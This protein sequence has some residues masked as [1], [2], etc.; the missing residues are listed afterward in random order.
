[1][2]N[3]LMCPVEV[4]A[5]KQGVCTTDLQPLL[6]G[7]PCSELTRLKALELLGADELW[8]W[9]LWEL[10]LWEWELWEWELW[11][12]ELWE[13]EL[14]ELELWSGTPKKRQRVVSPHIT[15]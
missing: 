7:S 11:E 5:V 9:E 15:M 12:L 4:G 14:W 8:E 6:D 13:W 3:V 2:T 1:M 10:E